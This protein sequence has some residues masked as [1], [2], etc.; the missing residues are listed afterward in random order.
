MSAV[1]LL[2]RL[3]HDSVANILKSALGT[4]SQFS[5]RRGPSGA[6]GSPGA[7]FARRG[8]LM[9]LQDIILFCLKTRLSLIESLAKLPLL[10]TLKSITID[11]LFIYHVGGSH[12]ECDSPEPSMRSETMS[13][14]TIPSQGTSSRVYCYGSSQMPEQLLLHCFGVRLAYISWL[15]PGPLSHCSQC[16][17]SLLPPRTHPPS[18]VFTFTSAPSF[19]FILDF[20]ASIPAQLGVS[21]RCNEHRKEAEHSVTH[22]LSHTLTRT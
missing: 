22:T 1:G 21:L 4:N 2:E 6:A 12:W 10:S 9:A 15:L 20:H 18:G 14:Q 5:L 19:L 13:C 3:H 7:S 8:C 17:M 11:I 16:F